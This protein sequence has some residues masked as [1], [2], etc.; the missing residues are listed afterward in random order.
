MEEAIIKQTQDQ[1]R[2]HPIIRDTLELLRHKLPPTLS[3][4]TLAHTEDVLDEAMRFGVTDHLTARQLELL[5]IA[6]ACHDVGFIE[7][8]SSNE[9]LGAAFAREEMRKHGGYSQDEIAL[10]ERMILDT[11]MVQTEGG[12]RQI[13]STELSRY[14][15]DADL[16]NLGRDDFFAKGELQRKELGQDL[17][18]FRIQTLALLNAHQWFTDAAKNIRQEKKEANV[19]LVASMIVAQNS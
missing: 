10:V 13:P 2:L 14:L 16:S 4:H 8:P 6:S 17:E 3:Y 12:P 9:A 11:T 19:K 18:E 5:A 7:I 15:L 1:M